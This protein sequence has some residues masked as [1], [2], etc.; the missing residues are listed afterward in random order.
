MDKSLNSELIQNLSDI[1]FKHM[2]AAPETKVLVIYDLQSPLSK[3]MYEGYHTALQNRPYTEFIDFDSLPMEDVE[4]KAKTLSPNDI[5]ILVQSMSFR[6]SVYRWRLELFERGLKVVEHVRLSQVK[7]NEYETYVNSLTF[8]VPYTKPL[9]QNLARLLENTHHIRVECQNGSVLEYFSEMEKPFMNLGDLQSEKQKGGYY[10]VGEIFSEP[11]DFGQVNGEVE[12]YAYP[13]EDHQ[14]RFTD[15]PF[16]M[17]IRNG[18]VVSGDFPS[19]FQPLIDLLKTE[20][21]DGKIP[22]REFGLGLNRKITK[23]NTLT[24]AT[25]F[26]RVTG[27]HL[28]LGMKH[29][30]YQKKFKGKDIAQRFHVD[31]Y[32]DVQRIWISDTL[33]FENG[34]YVL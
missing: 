10:P 13:G 28:S 30:I 20:N 3:I 24:E 2:Q 19:D 22:V 18:M 4:A 31:V 8:D 32:P 17:E 5:V 12:I 16:K 27:L 34:R 21:P 25:S 15:K 6:V 26:E 11:K 14:M 7:E 1:V 29:G 33:V 23:K 9:A